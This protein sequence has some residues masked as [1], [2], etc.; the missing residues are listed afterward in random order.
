MIC[1]VI[2]RVPHRP[3]VSNFGGCTSVTEKYR[4]N[5]LKI[6]GY[7]VKE[8]Q[9]S[10]GYY[11]QIFHHVNQHV[12]CRGL[13]YPRFLI[14][15]TWACSLRFQLLNTSVVCITITQTVESGFPGYFAMQ[16]ILSQS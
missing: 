3:I 10:T 4:G 6:P 13:R 5:V 12:I 16:C 14:L 11:R 1:F 2:T 8:C 7:N 9:L 15:K